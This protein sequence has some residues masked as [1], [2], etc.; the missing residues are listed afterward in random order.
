MSFALGDA[1][2]SAAVHASTGSRSQRETGLRELIEQA[3]GAATTEGLAQALGA[4]TDGA[5][6]G[7]APVVAGAAGRGGDS[8]G[9]VGL[10]VALL[11]AADSAEA[12][13][14]GTGEASGDLRFSALAGAWLRAGAT[15]LAAE[16]GGPPRT[17][18]TDALARMAEGRVLD[19]KD[20][21]DAGRTAERYLAAAEATR[22]SLI[23][24]AASL[25]ALA[26]GDTNA[27]EALAA[28][29]TGLG[30]AAAIRDELVA[31]MLEPAPRAGPAGTALRQG[32]YG[33]PVI[34]AVEEDGT[35]A[36]SLGG[37]IAGEALEELIARI[38]AGTGP[39]RAA[40]DCRKL[41]QVA[42]AAIEGLT[43]REELVA[44]ATGVAETA[45]QAVRA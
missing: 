31:L 44:L 41:V 35:L 25:G 7:F 2:S 18:V 24:L 12:E 29:G 30:A 16:L 1:L 17:A 22:G 36:R 34:R 38:R 10:I 40:D 6:E 11:E 5:E 4:S 15:E 26:Q 19:A 9:K 20:L 39:A 32:A 8:A 3:V 14:H 21:Y 42:T 13:V 23:A 28:F 33:L 37:A 45:S 43:G 27:V